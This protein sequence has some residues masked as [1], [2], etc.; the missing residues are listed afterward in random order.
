[1]CLGTGRK[2]QCTN[3]MRPESVAVRSKAPSVLDDTN[4]GI[5][6]SNTAWGMDVCPS[7]FY[8]TLSC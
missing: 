7:C 5:V 1:M 6:C 4:T 8:V 3:F 2:A